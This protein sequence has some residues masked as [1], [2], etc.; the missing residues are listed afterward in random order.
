MSSQD[1]AQVWLHELLERAADLI[2]GDIPEAPE[3]RIRQV[4]FLAPIEPPG[5]NAR[6]FDV[7]WDRAPCGVDLRPGAVH[8]GWSGTRWWVAALAAGQAS[9]LWARL[10]DEN[11]GREVAR[12]QLARTTRSVMGFGDAPDAP[13]EDWRVDV[14][15]SPDLGIRCYR[16]HRRKACDQRAY[17]KDLRT[18][19]LRAGFEGQV[20]A[21]TKLLEVRPDIAEAVLAR[22]VAI[23]AP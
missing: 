16:H 13:A 5:V 4:R 21:A 9:D 14:V 22:S 6:A 20:Q 12:C 18:C 7:E 15:R 10:I 23:A 11:T 8:A 17:L 1:D 19:I 2:P 3:D